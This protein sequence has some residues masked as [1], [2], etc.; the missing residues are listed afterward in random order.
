MTLSAT[1][2]LASLGLAQAAEP[3]CQAKTG[4]KPA[5]LIELYTSEGCDSCPPADRWLSTLKANQQA[6]PLAWHVD[7]WDYIGWKDRFARADAA[8]RQRSQVQLQGDR[9]AYTPQVIV[10]GKT[11]SISAVPRRIEEVANAG[12]AV[13]LSISQGIALHGYIGVELEGTS[14]GAPA[15]AFIALVEDG[16]VSEVKAGE[17]KGATLR[18]DHV[19]RE[20]IGPLPLRSERLSHL[21]SIAVPPG[22]DPSKLRA[23]AWAQDAQ[24]R[25]LNAVATQCQ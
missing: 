12:S 2:A 15:Q 9:T 14:R 16:L 21:H 7:Y 13:S 23:V 19:V 18:H 5:A 10:S 4:A 20:V 17:N 22:S 6:V 3:G 24:G 8:A 11:T 1:V 25:V